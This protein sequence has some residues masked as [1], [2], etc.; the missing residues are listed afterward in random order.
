M[1]TTNCSAGFATD[2]L[3]QHGQTEP[4]A[5][6]LVTYW[7]TTSLFVFFSLA[8]ALKKFSLWI[9]RTRKKQASATKPVK[10]RHRFPIFPLLSIF[11]AVSK[12]I[13]VILAGLNVI[14]V[15][16]GFSFS[17]FSINFFAFMIEVTLS[18][19]KVVSLGEKV[20]PLFE[21]DNLQ[22]LRRF[23]AIGLAVFIFQSLAAFFSS[24]VLIFI[25]PIFP[26]YYLILGKLGFALK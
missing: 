17:L 2:N 11:T 5:T 23:E 24:I 25:T 10:F 14:N 7:I 16:N 4:C 3:F 26:D 18:L 1:N 20:S 19:L 8:A 15:N 12:L 6:S 22:Y 9:T 21:S 13:C